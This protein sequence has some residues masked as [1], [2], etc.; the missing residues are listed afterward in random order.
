MIRGNTVGFPNPQP[1]WR[2]TDPLQADYIKNKPTGASIE[3][4]NEE[5]RVLVASDAGKFIRVDVASNIVVPANVFDVGVELEIFRNTTSGV[6]I[7]ASDVMFAIPGMSALLPVTQ[8]IDTPY[9]S[10][11][12]KHIANNVWSVQGAI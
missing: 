2:Q 5:R 9:A 8:N 4:V 3:V 10:V 1:D 11:V 12:L 6:G 7:V